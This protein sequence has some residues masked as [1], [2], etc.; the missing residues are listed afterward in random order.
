MSVRPSTH[1]GG[2]IISRRTPGPVLE[3]GNE[4]GLHL[5]DFVLF[6]FVQIGYRCG[7]LKF[8]PNGGV[9][10]KLIRKLYGLIQRP[11]NFSADIRG[12]LR[13]TELSSA[14]E[15]SATKTMRV[16]IVPPIPAL[17]QFDLGLWVAP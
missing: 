4:E 3:F 12:R 16:L 2:N 17:L 8:C 9:I 6:V 1:E 14:A 15:N 10:G 13:R 7:L 5:A 11:R